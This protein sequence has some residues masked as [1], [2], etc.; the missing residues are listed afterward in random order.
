MSSL[1][2]ASG[3]DHPDAAAKHLSDAAALYACDR[4]DGTAYLAG[5]VAECSLKSVILVG[6]SGATTRDARGHD[7]GVLSGRALHWLSAAPFSGRTA[8]YQ[9]ALGLAPTIEA[10][11]SVES[12]YLPERLTQAEATTFFNEAEALYKATVLE[13]RKDGLL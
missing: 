1:R 4:W 2:M 3:E 12:R 7:L 10:R 8:K 6:T 9:P 5:Y 13:M 11:W